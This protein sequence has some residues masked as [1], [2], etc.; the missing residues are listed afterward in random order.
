MKRLTVPQQRMLIKG[1][2]T[3]NMKTVKKHCRACEL[4]GEGIPAMTKS[5]SKMLLD[6]GKKVGPKVVKELIIPLLM[7][8][9]KEQAGVGLSPAG[10]GLRLAGQGKKTSPW[11]THVKKVAKDNNIKF[12]EAMKIAGKTYKK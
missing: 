3:A 9:A 4:R 11:I 5:V 8:K 6:L 12:G 2:T 7:K 1:L 10:A